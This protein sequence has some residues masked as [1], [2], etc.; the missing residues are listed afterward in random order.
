MR[1]FRSENYGI[2]FLLPARAFEPRRARRTGSGV[3]LGACA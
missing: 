2:Y 3:M 1:L